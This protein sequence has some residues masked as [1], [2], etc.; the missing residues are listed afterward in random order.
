MAGSGALYGNEHRSQIGVILS[1]QGIQHP[2][3]SGWAWG[4]PRAAGHALG[5]RELRLESALDA[6]VDE[7]RKVHSVALLQLRSHPVTSPYDLSTEW[8]TAHA[9]H[10]PVRYRGEQ[11]VVDRDLLPTR[12]IATSFEAG[13][14]P[15][16]QIRVTRVIPSSDLFVVGEEQVD[17]LADPGT[18]VPATSARES[19]Q[20]IVVDDATPQDCDNFALLDRCRGK[21][22][23]A[24]DS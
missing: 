11:R 14:V 3:Y 23:Q 17:A 16:P 20:L 18:V 8:G 9:A 6:V 21:Q 22:A 4:A 19:T 13:R 15:H 7:R 5:A 24:L 10:L 1:G 2:D 12:D